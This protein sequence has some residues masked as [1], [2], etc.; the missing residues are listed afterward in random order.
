MLHRINSCGKTFCICTLIVV[1]AVF[2]VFA[3]DAGSEKVIAN[4]DGY[5][6]TQKQADDYLPVIAP[7]GGNYT[8][9]QL[10]DTILECELLSREYGFSHDSLD[11]KPYDQ[12]TATVE[13]KIQAARINIQKILNDYV[14]PQDVIESYYLSYPEKF[15]E[16]DAPGGGIIEMPLDR[17]LKNQIQFDIVEKKKKDIVKNAVDK[18]KQKYRIRI[19]SEDF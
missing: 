15:K 2:S 1:F 11:G 3:Q 8:K 19:M 16:G 7:K 5:R 4:G 17:N 9:K 6:L 12:G 13:M 10:L 14:L 18:L